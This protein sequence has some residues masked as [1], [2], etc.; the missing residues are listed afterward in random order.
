MGR[1][2]YEKVIFF[3]SSFTTRTCTRRCSATWINWFVRSTLLSEVGTI[4]ATIRPGCS[5]PSSWSSHASVECRNASTPPERSFSSN[6]L[7]FGGSSNF[8]VEVLF[9]LI[10]H[11]EM[12]C[13]C[14]YCF[15]FLGAF[16]NNRSKFLRI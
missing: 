14:S 6:I 2:L 13:F 16:K 1:K 8:Y 4:P 7:Y 5:A 15:I 11:S 10:A 3:N 9:L 12:R